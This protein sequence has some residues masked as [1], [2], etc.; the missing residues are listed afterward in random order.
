[1]L[2]SLCTLG[3]VERAKDMDDV[4]RAKDEQLHDLAWRQKIRN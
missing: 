4:E 2:F 1:M 3:D